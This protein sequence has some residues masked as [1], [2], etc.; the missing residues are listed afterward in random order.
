M[1]I[2]TTKNTKGTK[3]DQSEAS[4]QQSEEQAGETKFFR[5]DES[6]QAGTSSQQDLQDRGWNHRTEKGS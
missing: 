6:R 5:R 2:F 4:S 1:N 3:Q